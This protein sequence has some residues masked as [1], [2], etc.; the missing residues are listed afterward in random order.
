ML[1]RFDGRTPFAD[2]VNGHA[3]RSGLDATRAWLHVE[4]FAR[5]AL[6]QGFLSTDGAAPA[7]YL[8]RQS[9]LE[10]TRLN[11]F[12]VQVNDFCNLSCGHCLVSSGPLRDQGLKTGRIL[13]IG[14]EGLDVYNTMLDAMGASRR[15]GPADRK[16][17]PV[18]AIRV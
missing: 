13:D 8:G 5:D 9:Y 11:E 4:T 7:P 16:M 1:G 15:L 17:S 14:A 18:D 2:V 3:F 12:W 10:T 6:R